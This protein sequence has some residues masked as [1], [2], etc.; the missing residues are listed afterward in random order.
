MIA[1]RRRAVLIGITAVVSLAAVELLA[2][3][4]EWARDALFPAAHPFV[5]AANPVPVFEP[6]EFEGRPVY[7]RTRHHPLMMPDQRFAAPKPANGFRVFLLGGSA[8][9][10]W[11]FDFSGS[12]HTIAQLLRRKLEM[13]LPDRQVEVVDAAGGTYASHRVRF[14]F[15]EIIDYE[16]DLVLVY[17]G[18]NEFLEHFVF[19]PRLPP[20]PWSRIALMR[21]LH[22]GLSQWSARPSFDVE[23]Y[24]LAD[25]TSNRLAYAFGRAS[26]YTE[27]P[28]QLDELVAHY[29]H[30]LDSMV[31]EARERGVSILLLNVPVN[32][33]DWIPNA[34]RHGTDLSEAELGRWQRHFTEGVLALEAGDAAG[35]ARALEA[36][37]AL[38]AAHA[39]SHYRLAIAL[40]RLGR[41]A[42]AKA[43]YAMAV[44]RDAYPFRAIPAF[45][46]I[47]GELAR[48]HGIPRVDIVSALER[49]AEDGILGLDVLV[50]YV[51][52]SEESQEVVAHEVVRAME[53]AGLFPASP[54]LPLAATRIEIP[55][56]F[57][58]WVEVRET[59][60][61][62]RQY[63]VMRQYDELDAIFERLEDVM[64]RAPLERP[65]LAAYCAE[66]LQMAYR[67]QAVVDPY[68][69]LLRAEKLGRVGQEFTR[70]K[71]RHIYGD[72]VRMIR[73][74]EAPRLSPERFR[75]LVPP[76]R[77]PG[78]TGAAGRASGADEP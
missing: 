28:Q 59:Q 12:E 67:I 39:E 9:G 42:D 11:P 16:P 71:A 70:E 65:D 26:R 48:E 77:Y 20:E 69:R 41:I 68:R 23:N 56:G 52:L 64:I 24:T 72:Y 4:M 2:R 25:Q 19:R 21:I 49:R 50:D 73:A 76:L 34:S 47:I 17:S 44:E 62:Y 8:A 27:D 78:P 15:D 74:F 45:Q 40:H 58:P 29:R 43:A 7:R 30:N 18:N 54:A 14:V 75:E 33:K 46:R 37:V 22:R 57:R 60:L 63:L 32:M 61:L 31:R 10:G 55:R 53:D 66:R 13:L 51:H 3:G 5:D 35:A 36:A 1:R 38:D 6:G